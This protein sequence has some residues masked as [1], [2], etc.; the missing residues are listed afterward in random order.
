[1]EIEVLMVISTL[2]MK[3]AWKTSWSIRDSEEKEVGGDQNKQAQLW[4]GKR[5]AVLSYSK[6]GFNDG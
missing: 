3:P 6:V 2:I 1:M 5:G 4:E